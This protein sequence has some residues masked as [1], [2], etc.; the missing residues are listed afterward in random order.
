MS[1]AALQTK[2]QS[3]NDSHDHDLLNAASGS[4]L[5]NEQANNA[6][7]L[8]NVDLSSKSSNISYTSL[9]EVEKFNAREAAIRDTDKK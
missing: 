8:S 3:K 6:K 5:S 9:E 7:G 1:G 2:G 4:D